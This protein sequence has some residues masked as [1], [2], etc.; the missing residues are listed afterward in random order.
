MV[1]EIQIPTL[2]D[3]A[4]KTTIRN[5]LKE[6][7]LDIQDKDRGYYDRLVGAVHGMVSTGKYDSMKIIIHVLGKYMKKVPVV[8]L[9]IQLY[10]NNRIVKVYELTWN[11]KHIIYVNH[12]E[13]SQEKQYLRYL[14]EIA[15][16]SHILFP[17]NKRSWKVTHRGYNKAIYD[18]FNNL[19]FIEDMLQSKNAMKFYYLTKYG[20]LLRWDM[21][22]TK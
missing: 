15:E 18:Y 16:H 6:I 2:T 22:I 17:H 19:R 12:V 8:K 1:T 4:I 20:Y 10:N 5:I 3:K 21:I 7:D 9:V 11:V 13:P 14:L